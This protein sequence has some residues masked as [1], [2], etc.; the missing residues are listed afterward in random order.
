MGSE[1]KV[2][3]RDLVQAVRSTGYIQTHR[4]SLTDG[5]LDNV[6]PHLRWCTLE[7]ARKTLENTTHLDKMENRQPMCPHIKARF[8]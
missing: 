2:D 6:H 4:K 5:E 1:D 8:P 3:L 7:V